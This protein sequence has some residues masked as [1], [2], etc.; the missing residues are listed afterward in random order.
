MV[1]VITHT[2]LREKKAMADLRA[3]LN[4][5]S[6][7]Q[8]IVYHILLDTFNILRFDSCPQL[9]KV[10]TENISSSN[11]CT[12]SK[13][14]MDLNIVG[15]NKE[16]FKGITQHAAQLWNSAPQHI[17]ETSH[18]PLFKKLKALGPRN[19][20]VTY[21]ICM[22]IASYYLLLIVTLHFIYDVTLP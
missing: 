15:H 16:K 13:T 21:A 18:Y 22:T 3:Q 6:V 19:A 8:L 17:R 11:L 1:R 20:S 2:Q 14:R 9:K 12:R 7:N 5:M 4:M 10:L